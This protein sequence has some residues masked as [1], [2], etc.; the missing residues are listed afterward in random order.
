[1][2]PQISS[3]KVSF[4]ADALIGVH[5]HERLGSQALNI[6]LEVFSNQ[7]S[8]D[9]LIQGLKASFKEYTHKE[10]P[11]LLERM[12]YGLTLTLKNTWPQIDSFLVTIEKPGALYDAECS[13]AS[14]FFKG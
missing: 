10:Q 2:K 7:F 13:F 3:I 11:F 1:M 5:A 9:E 6:A 4:T 14:L 8:K 12:V